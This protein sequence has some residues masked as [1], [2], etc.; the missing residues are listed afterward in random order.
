MYKEQ[1]VVLCFSLIL[2]QMIGQ[3]FTAKS[4][5]PARSMWSYTQQ[6]GPTHRNVSS[7][8]RR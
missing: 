5:G 8:Y 1:I 7:P 6:C 2:L 4:C 3:P